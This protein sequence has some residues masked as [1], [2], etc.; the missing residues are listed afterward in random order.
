MSLG[1]GLRKKIITKMSLFT[2]DAIVLKQFDLG[3]A[4]KIITFYTKEMG[5]VRA[6]A[7]GVR[8]TKSP[9]SG[10]VLPFSYNNVT[11]YRGRSLDRI[12]DIR[13]K[14]SFSALREDLT[15]MAYASYMA[16]LVEKVGMENDPNEDLFSLLL[17]S[18]YRLLRI[19]DE[20]INYVDLAF[21]TRILGILG[22]QPE[23]EKCIYCS[24]P[25]SLQE[26]NYFSI[27][28]GGLACTSC[29]S[30]KKE[31]IASLSGESL[32]VFKKLLNTGLQPIDKLKIS[33]G[34]LIE[35]DKLIDSFI[36]YHLDI[37]LKSFNF[38]HMIKDLG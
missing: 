3:E 14:Y 11:I 21:K 9:I 23:L 27:E 1:K 38:L 29:Y 36:I 13:N 33:K 31:R 20:R 2:T 6:V 8:K 4:D 19:E 16:E 32:Q 25:I 15:R 24:K 17:T 10:L 34:A 26:H 30:G 5:K 28:Q 7:R 12:N 18:F 35:L 37:R 22:V